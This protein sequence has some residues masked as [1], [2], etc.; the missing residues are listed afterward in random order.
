MKVVS[1]LKIYNFP[2]NNLVRRAIYQL[3]WEHHNFH[4]INISNS[5]Q[6][7][8]CFIV[9]ETETNNRKLAIRY[10]SQLVRAPVRYKIWWQ[11]STLSN[12]T[13]YFQLMQFVC[14]DL[15]SYCHGN[16]VKKHHYLAMKFLIYWNGKYG[17]IIGKG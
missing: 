17:C 8:E 4:S 15:T 12:P 16:V 14:I 6:F 3:N 11:M 5:N 1:W 2:T 13:L 9:I 7:V 10:L